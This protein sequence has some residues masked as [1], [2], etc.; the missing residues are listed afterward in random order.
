MPSFLSRMPQN[1]NNI[2]CLFPLDFH[3]SFDKPQDTENKQA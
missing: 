2:F 1:I 3:S